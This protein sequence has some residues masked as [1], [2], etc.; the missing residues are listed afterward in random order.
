LFIQEFDFLIFEGEIKNGLCPE[1]HSAASVGRYKL[2]G[3]LQ[4]HDVPEETSCA[5][6]RIRFSW[7]FK[8]Y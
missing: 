4:M 8:P 5:Y 2:F 7:T 6:A 1:V 3:F